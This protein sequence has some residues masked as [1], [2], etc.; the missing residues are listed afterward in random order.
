M[1]KLFSVETSTRA[2]RHHGKTSNKLEA[3]ARKLSGGSRIVKAADDAAGLSIVSKS[4]AITRS[5]QVA[6]RNTSNAI[7]IVQVMEGRLTGMSAS[8]V[9]IR[10]LA[11][12][13]SSDT[14][15]DSERAMQNKEAQE[16]LK[17]IDR[18]NDSTRFNGRNLFS[19][20]EGSLEIQVDS[21]TKKDSRIKI[22]LNRM[23][24]STHALGVKDALLDTQHRARLSLAKIDHAIKEVSSSAAFL[25]S[26]QKRFQHTMNKVGNDVVNGKGA[27]SKIA[28]TDYASE[29]AKKAKNSILESAQT[30]VMSQANNL[31]RNYLKLLG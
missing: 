16:L 8:L 1:S 28:D 4:N 13:A 11:I 5:K 9:R 20:K 17:E 14:Y 21:G 31:G 25:G 26:V 22:D 15:S 27:E 12:A 10:E 29:S 24:H 30:T 23:A 7:S 2:I 3:N 19:G 18:V 6:N